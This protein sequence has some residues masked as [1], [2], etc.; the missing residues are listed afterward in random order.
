MKGKAAQAK[1]QKFGATLSAMVMPNIG[2]FIGWGVLTALFIDTGW[3]PNA[4][5]NKLVSPIL[6][7]LLPILIGYTAG[8]NVH[9]HGAEAIW[10][11]AQGAWAYERERLYLRLLSPGGR[12]HSEAG[13]CPVLGRVL[14]RCVRQQRAWRQV[15]SQL[16]H[17]GNDGLNRRLRAG[18]RLSDR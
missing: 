16:R 11:A 3:C 9:V 7:Y 10:K 5:W 4:Y 8:Y 15:Q 2:I 1:I 14:G 17:F 6:T 13:R 18:V 12:Q